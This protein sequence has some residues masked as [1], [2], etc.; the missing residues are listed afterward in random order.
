MCRKVRGDV[1]GCEGG[2]KRRGEVWGEK[3]GEVWG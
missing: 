3:W 1:K 2:E